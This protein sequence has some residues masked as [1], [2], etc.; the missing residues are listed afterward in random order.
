M[1]LLNEFQQGSA[2]WV[3]VRLGIPTASQ[4]DRIITPTGK[5][6]SAVDKYA[7]E[8]IAEQL[9]GEPLKDASSGFMERGTLNEE[10]AAS[11]YELQRDVDTVPV[12]FIMRDDRRAGASPD[13][14]V[15]EDGLLEIKV[16]AANTHI[17]YLLD[18]KGIGYKCQVQGQ[19]WIAERAWCDTLSW[20]PTFPPALVRQHRD[21]AFIK[22]LAAG[23]EQ[24][25]DYVDELKLKLQKQCGLFP[26]LETRVLKVVA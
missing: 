25:C 14:L 20:H 19:L 23:V 6:S 2:E 26:D 12:G 1:I 18:D 22:V 3:R 11:Y 4:F 17:G 7:H 15:G 5:P 13:R 10:R 8:L 21:E 16:P 24:F 9:L